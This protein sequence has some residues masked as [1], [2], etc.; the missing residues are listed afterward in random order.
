MSSERRQSVEE[1]ADLGPELDGV[2]PVTEAEVGTFQR[3]GQVIIRGLASP[4]EVAAYRTL[5]E[6]AALGTPKHAAS[7]DEGEVYA[8]A[9]DQYINLWQRDARVA[10]FTLSRRFARV[11]AALLEASGVRLYHDQALFKQAGGGRTP[12]HQDMHYWPL[13]TDHALTM[14]MPLVD[15]T[16]DM[17]ELIFAAGSHHDGAMADV[18]I[19]GSSDAILEKELATRGYPLKA[20]GTMAAGDASFHAS[21]TLHSASANRTGTQREVMTLIWFEDGAR[22]IA[23]TNDGQRADLENWFP[24]LM[25]GD[26][27]ASPLNPNPLD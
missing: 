8:Q 2:H 22:L 10:A 3:D 11:A 18:P 19:S 21:W 14:W 1:R 7:A 9:F 17:G 5:I 4:T 25:P 23:P 20:T 27:A 13:S 12:W 26:L 16:P 15:L 6:E 24:G